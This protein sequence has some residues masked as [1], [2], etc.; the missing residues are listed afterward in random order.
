MDP[1]VPDHPH[2]DPAQPGDHGVGEISYFLPAQVMLHL[3]HDPRLPVDVLAGDLRN[4]LYDQ[5]SGQSW[6]KELV[7]PPTEKIMT[8]PV[9]SNGTVLSLAPARLVNE[10]ASPREVVALLLEVYKRHGAEPIPIQSASGLHLSLRSLSPNWLISDLSHGIGI[11][12]P[13]GWPKRAALEAGQKPQFQFPEASALYEHTP[14]QG[15]GVDVVILDTAP[16]LHDLAEAYEKWS[17]P[18][19]PDIVSPNLLVESLL[20]PGGPLRVVPAVLEDLRLA[21][22]F[23]VRGHR[24]LMPDHGLFVAGVIHSLAP[25]ARLHLYEVLNP[26]GIGC[27]ETIM[28]GLIRLLQDPQVSR[29]VILNCSLMLDIP[30]TLHGDPDLTGGPLPVGFANQVVSPL[31]D[32]FARLAQAGVV[33]VAAAGNDAVKQPG[34]PGRIPRP[35]AR[36]PAAFDSV[37]GVGAL[38]RPPYPRPARKATYS[39]LADRPNGAGYVTLGGEDGEELGMLGVFTGGFPGYMDAFPADPHQV[40]AER[41]RYD[42]NDTGWAWWAGTSFATPVVAGILANWWNAASGSPENVAATILGWASTA[43][44]E[45]NEHVIFVDQVR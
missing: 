37:I 14:G 45:N 44:S 25:L 17:A 6:K 15:A 24:Y 18:H 43:L 28:N 20:R 3:W 16:C 39:N 11:G 23:S 34:K 9:E 12:G 38:G 19:F 2:P 27:V 4:Y 1:N 41:V 42:P 26:Y 5:D 22:P 29:P 21:A 36:F 33:A 32:L 35:P 8:L 30:S 10:A 40:R 13:G 31:Q 7:P